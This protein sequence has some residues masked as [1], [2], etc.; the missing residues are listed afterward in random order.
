MPMASKGLKLKAWGSTISIHWP[1]IPGF[2]FI[3]LLSPL[4]SASAPSSSGGPRTQS[5]R[6]I[7]DS[8][9]FVSMGSEPTLLSEMHTLLNVYG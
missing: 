9:R 7:V 5:K 2:L 1:S 3:S 8:E 4:Y 6:G